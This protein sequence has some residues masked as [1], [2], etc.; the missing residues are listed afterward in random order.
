MLLQFGIINH[1]PEIFTTIINPCPEINRFPPNQQ[2]QKYF[3]PTEM[4]NVLQLRVI[5]CRKPNEFSKKTEKKA[6]VLG[7]MTKNFSNE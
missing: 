3:Q 2:S 5:T 4:G 1:P 6:K 7:N